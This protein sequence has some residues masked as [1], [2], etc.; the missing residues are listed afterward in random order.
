MKRCTSCGSIY[1]NDVFTV[2]PHD[3]TQ[4]VAAGTRPP[5]VDPLIGRVIENRYRIDGLLGAGGMGSVYEAVQL[6]ID[7]VVALKVIKGDVTE[8]MTRRFLLEAKM[9]SALRSVHT[10]TIYDFGSS[11]NMLFFAMEKLIGRPLDD[12]LADDGALEWRRALR[13][14]SQICQSL[15]EAHAMGIIHRDLKPANVMLTTQ[16]SNEDFARVLDF[17]VAKVLS[18]GTT[19]NLT[20]TG[21]I[22]GTPLYMAP[23]QARADFADA[24]SDIYSVGVML[25]EMLSGVPPFRGESPISV[26]MKHCQDPVPPLEGEPPGPLPAPVRQLVSDMLRKAADKRPQSAAELRR[27]VDDL[28]AERF[29]TDVG[30]EAVT[31]PA[32]TTPSESAVK[33]AAA[34]IDVT[35]ARGGPA[36]APAASSTGHALESEAV[37]APPLTRQPRWAL[38]AA[39]A[40]F[41][42]IALGVG[43]FLTLGPSGDSGSAAASPAPGEV[44]PVASSVEPT[45]PTPAAAVEPADT[46]EDPAVALPTPAPATPSA[47]TPSATGTAAEQKAR[48]EAPAEDEIADLELPTTVM[49]SSVP[50]GARVLDDAGVGLGATP[51]EIE[52]PDVTRTY[53]VEHEGHSPTTFDLGPSV[54]RLEPVALAKLPSAPP[55]ARIGPRPTGTKRKQAPTGRKKT[56]AKK[57]ATPTTA[58]PPALL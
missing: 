11:G 36:V 13:I 57:K 26:L 22:V 52:R 58:P 35:R 56:R 43:L 31:A 19:A 34:E 29:E 27:R 14:V 7:R 32:R 44:G 51:L 54:E 30:S 15:E 10:V 20:G 6:S 42:A 17:G 41:I 18:Q 1:E 39:V 5:K 53:R 38:P 23:E 9:T 33:L 12:V 16:G 3:G 47:A 28:I 50:A 4:L 37:F 46:P 25:Y 24:R 48:P 40:A 8:D 49:V 55:S 21:M 2:C 45:S